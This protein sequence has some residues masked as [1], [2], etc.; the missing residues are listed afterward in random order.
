MAEDYKSPGWYPAP[1]GSPGE[2]WWNGAG[3]SE[4]RRGA[5]AVP[6]PTV[7]PA[8]GNPAP[9]RPDPYA[10]GPTAPAQFGSAAP[11]AASAYAGRTNPLATVALV[12]GAISAFGFGIA[13]PVALVLSIIAIARA[14]RL[15]AEGAPGSSIVLALIG[16]GLGVI[17][18][19]QLIVFFVVLLAGIGD[20]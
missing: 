6:A 3:W 2:R 11:A 16:L 20:S 7:A 15:K 1:D 14:R 13:G 8:V 19:I 5:A 4:S 12:V 10:S 17:G 9:P 18:T